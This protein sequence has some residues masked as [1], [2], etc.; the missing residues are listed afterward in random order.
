MSKAAR[1]TV[2]NGVLLTTLAMHGGGR[3]NLDSVVKINDFGEI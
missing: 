1:L 3:T 2:H